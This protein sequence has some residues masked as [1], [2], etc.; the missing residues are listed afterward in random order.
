MARRRKGEIVEWKLTIPAWL[1]WE[2]ECLCYNPMRGKAEYGARSQLITE[3]LISH[4]E[5][6]RKRKTDDTSRSL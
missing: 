6:L 3:L 5:A 4:L 1:A 2:V